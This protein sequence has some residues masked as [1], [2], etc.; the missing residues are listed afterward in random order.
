MRLTKHPDLGHKQPL[1]VDKLGLE[2]PLALCCSGPTETE[3]N[4]G[5]GR[6]KKTDRQEVGLAHRGESVPTSCGVL[7]FCD[8]MDW[9][10]EEGSR[11]LLKLSGTAYC[12]YL[13][14]MSSSSM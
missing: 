14:T 11:R 4:H 2:N 8:G 13:D 1:A 3:E 10:L 12:R 7:I 6:D 9:S 5:R